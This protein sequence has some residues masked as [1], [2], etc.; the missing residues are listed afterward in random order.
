MAILVDTNVLIDI[1]TD[2]P[3]WADWSVAIL[4]QYADQELSINPA[5][6]AELCFDYNSVEEVDY[7]IRQFGLNYQEIP[8]DGL[9][10]AAKAFKVY[11]SR[12]GA[13][14]FVLPDFF[15]GGHAES[16]NSRLITRDVQR[17]RSYFPAVTIINP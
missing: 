4:E 15:I 9:F 5:I 3:K 7:L 12:G 14:D 6:Y 16:S 17:Y 1:V 13:K 10:R 8:R 2:D 11:K